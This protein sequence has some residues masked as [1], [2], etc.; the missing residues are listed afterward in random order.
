LPKKRRLS[1]R[2]QI[3]D[4]LLQELSESVDDNNTHENQENTENEVSDK[5]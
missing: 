3:A 4:L 1:I 2:K 5:A